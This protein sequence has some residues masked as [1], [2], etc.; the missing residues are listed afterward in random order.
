MYVI[1]RQESW[2]GMAQDVRRDQCNVLV[3]SVAGRRVEKEEKTAG[4]I[5]CHKEQKNKVKKTA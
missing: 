4:G 2:W 1:V 5:G 3:E